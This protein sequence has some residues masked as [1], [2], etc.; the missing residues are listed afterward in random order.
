MNVQLSVL[1][2]IFPISENEDSQSHE[3][4]FEEELETGLTTK[5]NDDR[6]RKSKSKKKSSRGSDRETVESEDGAEESE[7]GETVSDKKK[8]KKQGKNNQKKKEKGN[9]GNNIPEFQFTECTEYFLDFEQSEDHNQNHHSGD[10]LV[11][12]HITVHLDDAN[13][14]RI[15]VKCCQLVFT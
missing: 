8:N 4:S 6:P 12:T 14:E 1:N 5:R 2:V 13:R 15:K 9:K 11:I 7:N 10:N 3:S